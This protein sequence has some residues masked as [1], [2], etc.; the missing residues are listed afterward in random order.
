MARGLPH[1]NL[2]RPD[3]SFP[4]STSE[5]SRLNADKSGRV[6]MEAVQ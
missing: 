5:V 6:L 2:S 1:G 3:S 4:S